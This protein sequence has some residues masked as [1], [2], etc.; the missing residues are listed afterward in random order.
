VKTKDGEYRFRD[1]AWEQGEDKK[2]AEIFDFMKAIYPSL[3]SSNVPV[4]SK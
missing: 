2:V 1:V 4:D 3:V